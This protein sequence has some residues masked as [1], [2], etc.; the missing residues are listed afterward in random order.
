MIFGLGDRDFGLDDPDPPDDPVD[1]QIESLKQEIRTLET[2]IQVQ[3]AARE[4][5]AESS[6]ERK[7]REVAD[8]QRQ[9]VS[10]QHAL[11]Y[12]QRRATKFQTEMARRE[13]RLA[14]QQQQ[15]VSQ[16]D[17]E[18]FDK[19]AADLRA[20]NEQL[21]REL[22][23]LR[24]DLANEVGEGFDIDAI[25]Q[26]GGG[27]RRRIEEL[28]SLQAEVG[29]L[30]QQDVTAW[31]RRGLD[32]AAS[33]AT[34]GTDQLLSH[35]AGLEAQVDQMHNKIEKARAKLDGLEEANHALRLMDV[36]LQEKLRHDEELIRHLGE[37]QDSNPQ[38]LVL[39]EEDVQP[40]T[41]EFI[42]QLK[43]QRVIVQGL[44]YKLG[45]AQK[46]L[47]A[48]TVAVGYECLA[49]QV[50]QLWRRCKFLQ[51]QLLKR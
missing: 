12:E 26:S 5:D 34:A 47:S 27:E 21:G 18:F 25:L 31:T 32:K 22:R 3:S 23:D 20:Q 48:N 10:F 42:E 43:M 35:R 4:L 2:Q 15:L 11:E 40:L 6:V 14:E 24:G 9:L 44:L 51:T 38:H 45:L 39:P 1:A 30:Q 33:R 19:Q 41:E 49:G 50:A 13:G 7:Q 17:T 8:L 16:S 36:L 28:Q 37:F 46:E 29:R